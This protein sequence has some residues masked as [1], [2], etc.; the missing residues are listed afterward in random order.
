MGAST[1]AAPSRRTSEGAAR[2]RS[3]RRSPTSRWARGSSRRC[4]SATTSS[5]WSRAARLAA[6][7]RRLGRSGSRTRRWWRRRGARRRAETETQWRTSA[8]GTGTGRRDWRWTRNRPSS[9]L[10]GR[11]SWTNRMRSK[12]AHRPYSVER[13]SRDIARGLLLLGTACGLGS[14]HA[15]Y[16]S[17]WAHREE[18]WGLKKDDKQTARWFRKM[19]GCSIK[20]SSPAWRDDAAKWLRE[21]PTA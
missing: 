19:Q 10:S 11:R 3:S 8:F 15:F 1:S 2:R 12:R 5:A 20:N 14:E 7:R 6:T 16:L 9:G 21:H 18:V 4:R 17:G 13:A